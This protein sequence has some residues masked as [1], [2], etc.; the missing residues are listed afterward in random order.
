MPGQPPRC[1]PPLS[2]EPVS[3]ASPIALRSPWVLAVLQRH[4]SPLMSKGSGNWATMT[5]LWLSPPTPFILGILAFILPYAFK[6]SLIAVLMWDRQGCQK[7]YLFLFHPCPCRDGFS[8]PKATSAPLHHPAASLAPRLLVDPSALQHPK[9]SPFGC[10]FSQ[11]LNKVCATGL[12]FLKFNRTGGKISFPCPM[13]P[14]PG[15]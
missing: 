14:V 6:I 3:S 10:P 1:L 4:H 12:F 5:W 9:F 11:A 13:P 15:P 7:L 8:H 2:L